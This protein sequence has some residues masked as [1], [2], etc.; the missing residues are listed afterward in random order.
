[1]DFKKMRDSVK[2][3]SDDE[4]LF[5]NALL[6]QEGKKRFTPRE[7]FKKFPEGSTEPRIFCLDPQK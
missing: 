1:M 2:D 3:L 5:L 4:L 7:P 6:F